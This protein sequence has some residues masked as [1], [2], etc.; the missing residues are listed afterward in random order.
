MFML[1][2]QYFHHK[3][4]YTM[5]QL[6]NNLNQND[7]VE[8]V[9]INADHFFNFDAMLDK[10]YKRPEG[11]SVNRSHLFRMSHDKPGIIELKDSTDSEVRVQDLTK[12]SME[13]GERIS[14]LKK[15]LKE[16]AKITRPG[17]KPIKQIE[18]ATKWRPLVPKEYQDDV[19]PIPPAELVEKYKKDKG[20]ANQKKTSEIQN[21]NSNKDIIQKM[22][23]KQLQTELV[24]RKLPK[25][26]LKAV[27]VQRL[28]DAI[29]REKSKSNNTKTDN[30]QNNEKE[31]IVNKSS[32]RKTDT[33]K[34]PTL[35]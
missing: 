32:E 14:A 19:C 13:K 31:T 22:T 18:L 17:I 15:A 20:N 21:D 26:G 8:A 16:V 33:E 6:N 25:T 2:K 11:G 12:G 30:A 4:L 9:L 23:V 35:L 1:L 27:L 24:K 10:F 29:Q 28:R 3:N 7:G 5:Q 34:S